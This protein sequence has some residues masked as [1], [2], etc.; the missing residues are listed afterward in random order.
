ML[1]NK[2]KLIC[3]LFILL[4]NQFI[5]ESEIMLHSAYDIDEEPA[6][7]KKRKVVIIRID[8]YLEKVIPNLSEKQ[9]QMHF[10]INYLAYDKLLHVITT[11]IKKNNNIG[12]PLIDIHRQLL[13]VLWLLATPDSFRSVG[14]RFNMGKSSLSVS[15]VRIIKALNNIAAK[16]I[17]W[18]TRE[19]MEEAKQKF[20][21]IAGIDG[22]IGAVDGTFIPIKAPKN[23][24][25]V[26]ICRKCHYAITLQGICNAT[27][28]FIDVFAGYPGSVSD[29]RIFRNSDIYTAVTENAVGYFPNEEFI[30]GDKAYPCLSWCI[31]PYIN[32]G[33]MNVAKR[34]FNMKVSQT[35]QVI[36]RA[37]G[38][39]FG[40]LRRLKFLDMNRQDLI[41]AT[42]VACCAIHNLCIDSE[43][44]L[45]DEFV[46][47]GIQ[48]VIGNANVEN[49][50][51]RG[52]VLH[53]NGLHKRNQLCEQLYNELN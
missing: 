43:D 10:R 24:P 45:L 9:F 6:I 11:E 31:P 15:F 22:V 49:I 28:Q 2:R 19:R 13:A 7:S 23:D 16:V 51:N 17:V 34:N 37:F 42:V 53:E 32:T 38:L 30:L 40:R 21:R 47:E 25:E 41:P 44:L 3:G 5:S 27:L 52:N 48:F 14:E 1:I 12:R 33:N 39:L 50:E 26:Y 18:P 4:S 36:E 29:T 46:N 20:S 8:N 35:R